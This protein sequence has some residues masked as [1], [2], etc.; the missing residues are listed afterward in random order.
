MLSRKSLSLRV[1]P[2]GEL[3]T[4]CYILEYGGEAMAIDPG[5][6]AVILLSHL[7][8]LM[9]DRLK[10][11]VLTHGHCDHIGAVDI[12][13]REV[14]GELLM[15]EGDMRM[16]PDPMKNF[17]WYFGEPVN[18]KSKPGAIHDGDELTLGD[19]I[20]R[21]L[22]T[23]GHS[24]GSI[25]IWGDEKVFC[26]DLLFKGSIG[27]TDFPGG[28][29]DL[30]LASVS[31]KIFPLGEKTEVYPGHGDKTTVGFEMRQ[32]PFLTGLS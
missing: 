8:A 26:G 6:D 19:K 18:V 3:K 14:G 32:N 29:H 7:K 21:V 10:Y 4:N 2:V 5:D 24:E 27:R 9:S 16:L 22:H 12:I 17:S 20:F 1:Y 30:L 28:D 31:N 13:V 15:G 25:S 11:I 23:P